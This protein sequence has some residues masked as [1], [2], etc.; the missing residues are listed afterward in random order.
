VLLTPRTDGGGAQWSGTN[1]FP[2]RFGVGHLHVLPLAG[3]GKNEMSCK[4]EK[5]PRQKLSAG[6]IMRRILANNFKLI[7][8]MMMTPFR[9]SLLHHRETSLSF[10]SV[11]RCFSFL[12]FLI[13]KR[14]EK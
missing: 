2:P 11:A 7:Y 8:A 3:H 1:F 6:Y 13:S 10:P 5:N 4:T 9:F 12:L 14:K